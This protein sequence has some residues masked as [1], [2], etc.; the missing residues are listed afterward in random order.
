MHLPKILQK[1][2]QKFIKNFIH[3]QRSPY[4]TNTTLTGDF[5]IIAQLFYIVLPTT[6]R[7]PHTIYYISAIWYL[8]ISYAKSN[9]LYY[10]ADRCCTLGAFVS[11]CSHEKPLIAVSLVALQYVLSSIVSVCA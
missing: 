9:I 4:T 5:A 10:Q 6:S 8:I 7:N 11:H 2:I 3:I 1:F